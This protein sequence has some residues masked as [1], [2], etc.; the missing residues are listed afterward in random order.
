MGP[1]QV[2]VEDGN[3]LVLEVT[4]TPNTTVI[5][6]RG[7]AGPVG[8]QGPGDVDGPASSTDN[9]VA[10]FDGTTGKLIQ[11]SLVTVSDTGAVAGVTTLAASGAVTLSGGTANGVSYLNASKVL[12]TGSAL[13]FDGTSLGVNGLG[14]FGT[15]NVQRFVSTPLTTITLGDGAT[16]ANDVGIYFR[17]TSGAAGFSTVGAS[18]AWYTGGAGVSEQM[19]LTSTGLGIGTSSPAA[20]LDVVGNGAFSNSVPGGTMS[21]SFKNSASSAQANFCALYLQSIGDPGRFAII[22]V[23]NGGPAE[24]KNDLYFSTNPTGAGPTER[25]R[26]TSAG[27]VGIGTSSPEARLTVLGGT[28]SGTSFNTAVFTGGLVSTT[29]SGAKI[30]LSGSPGSGT[31]RAAVIEGVTTNSNNAHALVF[32]TNADF[33]TPAERMRLDSSGNLGLGVTP[34]AWASGAKAVQIKNY[35][36][37]FEDSAGGSIFSF[38]SYQ[39]ATGMRY[40]QTEAASR[41]LQVS[42]LHAWY[43]APSGTAGNAIS[44]SQV[45]TLDA[46]GNLGIGVT[47]PSV[48]LDV[49]GSMRIGFSASGQSITAFNGDQT[50]QQQIFMKMVGTDGQLFVTRAAGIA[51]NL[52]FGTEGSERARIDS[53]GNFLVGLTSATG[54]AKLQVSGAIRTTGFTVAT[55]PAGTV[56]MRTYVTDALAPSFGVTVVGGGAVTIP[57]FYNGANWIVA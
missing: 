4:P 34:S 49:N 16:P 41:Y 33:N 38:N 5:L 24:N 50:N 55:L 43:T 9:A 47:S 48:R 25:M 53:S 42:G 57:V 26:I 2:V 45:M 13:T 37:L 6:D 18:F 30:Y 10:R 54:V 44:F 32:Y 51:A 35:T 19:R 3:N 22:G 46:S 29:G 20:K 52:L 12:T 27:N 15:L 1:I 23:T 11:N 17:Q 39:S 40:I 8:P 31:T 21:V 14:N 56:G 7:I 28:T 36:T